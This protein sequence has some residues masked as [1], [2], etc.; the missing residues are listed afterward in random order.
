MRWLET[1]SFRSREI[2]QYF[3]LH[4]MMKLYSAGLVNKA[5]SVKRWN[6]L[7]IEV[8]AARYCFFKAFIHFRCLNFK[9]IITSVYFVY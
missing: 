9:I 3:P 2:I 1:V 8:S 6:M 4:K 7:K 5:S